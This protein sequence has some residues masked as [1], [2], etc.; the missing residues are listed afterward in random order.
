MTIW[1]SDSHT[2]AV[3]R[4]WA[5]NENINVTFLVIGVREPKHNVPQFLRRAA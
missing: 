5:V 3:I 4:C 2:K 1:N